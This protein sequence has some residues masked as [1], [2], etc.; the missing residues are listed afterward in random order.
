MESN[1]GIRLTTIDSGS[2]NPSLDSDSVTGTSR[3]IFKDNSNSKT[4]GFLY[5][6]V[7]LECVI[8]LECACMASDFLDVGL[9][10]LESVKCSEG[11]YCYGG[12]QRFKSN[13]KLNMGL[14]VG[15]DS[16]SV[17]MGF[18]IRDAEC[19]VMAALQKKEVAC[20]SVLQLQAV[21]VLSVIHFAF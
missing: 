19:Q 11:P 13:Y 8:V 21:V 1:S 20:V 5:V 12:D 14:C 2:T 18:M 4:S 17:G 10:A 7:F 15:K 9:R 16:K 3:D 6:F